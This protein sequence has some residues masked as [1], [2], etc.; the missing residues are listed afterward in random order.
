MDSPMA[1]KTTEPEEEDR[2]SALTDDVLLSILRKVNISTAAR[3]SS[4][5]TR[6]RQ[7][8]WLLPEL[9][10]DVRWF[11]PAPHSDP[12]EANDM[13]EAMV[14]LTKATRS[15]LSKP[16]RGST[17]ARLDLVIYLINTFLSDLGP[18]VGDAVDCGLLKDLDL[19]I[20]DGTDA[21]DRNEEYM[22]QRAQDIYG[23]FTAYPSVLHCLTKLSLYNVCFSELDINRVL[24][25]SCK[26]LKHLFLIYCDTGRHTPCKI[27]APNSKLSVLEIHFCRFEMLE[28]VCLPKLEKLT[29]YHWL[30]EYSPLLMCYVPSLGELELSSAL[31]LKHVP[32]KLSEVLHGTTSIHTLTLDFQGENLWMQPEMKQLCTAF[33]KLRKLS[34]RGIF[35]EFDII[36]TTAFLVA[37]PSIEILCIEVWDHDTCGWDDNYNRKLVFADRKNPEWEMDSHSSKNWLLKELQ[38]VGFRPLEQQFTFIRALLERAPNLQTIVLKGDIECV[39]DCVALIR[40]A[41]FPKTE[42]EQEMVV[43][44]ITDGKPSPRVIFYE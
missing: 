16:R 2:L 15:L 41:L 22:L 37:A 19:T 24:F 6:W 23:F 26:E 5:S 21:L 34:V 42:D 17:T 11:L 39:W 30:S 8:P 35:V 7:L 31:T 18:L 44:R 28:L 10:I 43:R 13:Q 29:W 33:N 20:H 40:E 4:L 27:D 9:S 1:N 36:W 3:T 38:I 12:I 32:F 25:D 14:A